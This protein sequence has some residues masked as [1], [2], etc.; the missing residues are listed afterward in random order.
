MKGLQRAARHGT[1]AT[2]FWTRPSHPP[3]RSRRAMLTAHSKKAIQRRLVLPLD[4]HDW[5]RALEVLD[6]SYATL[7]RSAEDY[8]RVIR[9]IAQE[10]APQRRWNALHTLNSLRDRAYMGEI[11]SSSELWVSLVWAYARLRYPH[12]G[13]ECLLQ[14]ERRFDF[15]SLTK[16]HLGETLLPL[17]AEHGM[18][19][20][21]KYVVENFLGTGGSRHDRARIAILVAEAAA[22]SG[23]WE[24]AI[25]TVQPRIDTSATGAN[26]RTLASLFVSEEANNAQEEAPQTSRNMWQLSTEALRCMM[27]S[28]ADDGRWRMAL[29]CLQELRRRCGND[30]LC[31]TSA[32]SGNNHRSGGAHS[33]VASETGEG[34]PSPLQ[35]E[36][37]QNQKHQELSLSE[38]ELQRLLNCLGSH[39]RWE[40]ATALFASQYFSDNCTTGNKK[41]RPLHST[42][43]NLLF[44]SFPRETKEYCLVAPDD[45]PEPHAS[46]IDPHWKGKETV[47]L[48]LDALHHPQHVVDLFDWLLSERDDVAVT[49]WVMAA[50]GPSLVQLGGWERA[51]HLLR[52]TPSFSSAKPPAC[53]LEAHRQVRKRLTALLYYLHGTISLESRYYTMYHF[54][55]AFPKEAFRDLPPPSE[56]LGRLKQRGEE[57]QTPLMTAP[58]APKTT[59]P[60]RFASQRLSAIVQH[61]EKYDDELRRRL[62]MLYANRANAFREDDAEKDP[63]PLPKGL[64]DTA[65]GWNFYGRGGE[66][67]FANHKRTAHP[68]SMHPKLM[69]SLADPYR[70]WNPMQN[71]CWAHRERVRKWNGS[72]AV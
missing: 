18:L 23:S 60:R 4:A 19:D 52:Q 6:A 39:H 67:V 17:L 27:C 12:E 24:H 7:G 50:V 71:S 20:E 37:R 1:Y 45:Q 21:V 9:G 56:L 48:Q 61:T 31:F 16:Q 13:Y 69:R 10:T 54:P 58:F 47:A 41:M 33:G 72:S 25:A 15:S 11:A 51:L 62:A 3:H 57:E 40:E 22:R 35:Q 49:D 55:F 59:T 46:S 68:F 66:M 2:Q 30:N 38:N 42:T 70:G 43:L 29:Q 8:Q 63:R 53:T 26:S 28:M 32:T 5:G 14:G 44:A 34:C 36:Q 65:N 64:H